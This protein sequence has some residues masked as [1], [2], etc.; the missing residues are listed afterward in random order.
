MRVLITNNTLDTRCGSELYVRDVALALLRRGHQPVAYS[1]RLGPVAEELRSL[2]IPAI[3]DLSALTAM[4]DVIHGQHHLDAMTAMV[5]FPETPAVYFC[6]GWL[7]W[8]EAAPRF[9]SIG[10][11]VAID[12]LCLER[13]QCV[14]GIEPER[15]RVIRNF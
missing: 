9:P 10:R 12:D 5:R 4:P 3:D 6:H 14:H 15:I 1:T 2:T 7:P 8:Q 13:L 11:Y